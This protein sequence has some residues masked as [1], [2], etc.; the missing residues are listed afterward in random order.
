MS[1]TSVFTLFC[2][3]E[4]EGINTLFQTFLLG[5]FQVLVQVAE[6]EKLQDHGIGTEGRKILMRF[7]II[8]GKAG[9]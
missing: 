3:E 8:A 5:V 4:G 7:T 6:R 2:S 1:S 9:K